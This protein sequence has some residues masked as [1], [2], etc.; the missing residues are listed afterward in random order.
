[1]SPCRTS[2][3]SA[4]SSFRGRRDEV[5][6]FFSDPREP[7]G[8][9]AAVASLRDRRG[10]R[11]LERGLAAALPAAA[12]GR[13]ARLAHGDHDLAPAA[14]L[15][16][17]PLAG[18]Y[19]LWE[20]AHRFRPVPGGTEVYDNVRYRVPGGPLAPLVNVVSALA[21]ADLRLPHRGG[22][23]SC[24]ARGDAGARGEW[25]RS[26]DTARAIDRFLES[27]AL[28][29]RRGGPTGPISRSSPLARRAPRRARATS[30]RASSPTTPRARRRPAGTAAAQALA[31]DARAQARR[32]ALVPAR[33]ARARAGPRPRAGRTPPAPAAPRAAP[34]ET[35]A[36]LAPSRRRA[37]RAPQPRALRARLLGRPPRAGGGRPRRSPTSTSSSEL[38]HVR[39]KGGKERAVPLGEEAVVP[40]APLPRARAARARPRRRE[41][42]SSSPPAGSRSTPRRCA[43]C[44]RTRTGSA[45]RSRPTCSRAAP[46]SGRSRSCSATRPSRRPRSTATSTPSDCARSMTAPTPAPDAAG[47]S[48]LALLAARRAPR[49]VD[50]YRRDLARP[51]AVPRP[52]ARRTRPSDEVQAGSPTC[53]P[54]GSSPSS[55]ARKAVGRADLLPPPRPPGRSARQPG[56]RHRPAAPPRTAAAHA[57]AGRDRAADRRGER[58]DAALASATARS[59]SSS[60]ARASASARR[61]GSSCG[62]DRPRRPARAL[63]RQGRQGAHRP[64][65]ARGSRGPAPLPRAAAV[66]TSTGATARSSS[67]TPRAARSRAPARS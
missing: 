58:D 15:H 16:R 2:R 54:A 34:A 37:A 44:S 36:L 26:M 51:R 8:D 39:G 35:D 17:R 40:A 63:H 61:S 57:L 5:W 24:S 38:I 48:F 31:H 30:T 59:S 33:H 45:M 12:A 14:R 13:S 27:P 67:S 22:S 64:A 20:H 50:A 46:T 10:A 28:S 21:G 47:E 53:A 7:R 19:P 3:S 55:I 23:G 62:G 56:R 43:G 65:R 42:R 41:P 4:R 66:R 29:D 6:A 52:P 25:T 49:T 11:A 9:H 32:R 60:T 1:M 18:P